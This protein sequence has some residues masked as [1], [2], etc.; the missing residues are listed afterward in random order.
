[1]CQRPETQPLFIP[2]TDVPTKRHVHVQLSILLLFHG[3]QSA[4]WEDKSETIAAR[5]KPPGG[6]FLNLT[7]GP[8]PLHVQISKGTGGSGSSESL[9]R[10][11]LGGPACQ[12][13][14]K[15]RQ[16]QASAW[17]IGGSERHGMAWRAMLPVHQET[18]QRPALKTGIAGFGFSFS[19]SVQRRQSNTSLLDGA[20][21]SILLYKTPQS[22]A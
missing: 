9:G 3:F 13:V 4:V 10:A 5:T 18:I 22:S 11:W 16:E 15:E 21:V 19:I 7:W 2:Q 6:T 20:A 17:K 12:L 1:M 14:W 8:S